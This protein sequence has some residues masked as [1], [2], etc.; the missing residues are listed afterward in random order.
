MAALF[1]KIYKGEGGSKKL[2]DGALRRE[3]G[4]VGGLKTTGDQLQFFSYPISTTNNDCQNVTL[5]KE[6]RFSRLL[7]AVVL[8]GPPERSISP[9]WRSRDRIKRYGLLCL[10]WGPGSGNTQSGALNGPRLRRK[11][12]GREAAPGASPVPTCRDSD[13]L[14]VTAAGTCTFSPRGPGAGQVG[15]ESKR[16]EEEAFC[17]R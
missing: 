9:L 17:L 2:F 8:A 1:A 4:R 14:L 11:R 10:C 6:A 13:F 7:T 12:A 16:S 5:N 3:E 15:M